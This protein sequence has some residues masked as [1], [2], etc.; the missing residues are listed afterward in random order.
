MVK[1]A[2]FLNKEADWGSSRQVEMVDDG[3]WHDIK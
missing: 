2:Q 3:L 1:I